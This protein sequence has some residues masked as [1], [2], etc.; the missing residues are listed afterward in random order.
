MDG[1]TFL[2]IVMAKHPAPVIVVSGRAG[3]DDVFKAL[4]LGAVD[5]V[6]KP[7][8]RATLELQSIQDVLIRKAHATRHLRIDKVSERIHAPPPMLAPPPRFRAQ[9][10]AGCRDCGSAGWD[11]RTPKGHE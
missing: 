3:E 1:F 4:D 8:L 2:R 10:Y 5:F 11:G 7:T 6:A 9:A